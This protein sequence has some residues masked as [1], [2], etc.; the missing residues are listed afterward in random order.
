MVTFKIDRFIKENF[1]K[2]DFNLKFQY[3][4]LM[5]NRWLGM[6]L[7]CFSNL[8]VFAVAMFG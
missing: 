2:V 3:A 6:R 8:I 5:C 7:E 1:E 4:S